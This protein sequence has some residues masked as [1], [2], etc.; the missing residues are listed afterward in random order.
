MNVL[1]AVGEPLWF[2]RYATS[3]VFPAFS[4]PTLRVS[5]RNEVIESGSLKS[6][7][8]WFE[9]TNPSLDITIL[10][11]HGGG[12]CTLSVDAYE[13]SIR[14]LARRL[15]C[16]IVSVDYRRAPEHPY[17]QIIGEALFVYAHLTEKLGIPASKI[18]V[19]GDSAGGNI[20]MSLCWKYERF[21]HYKFVKILLY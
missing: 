10:H 5:R 6:N 1:L 4:L 17:P 9:P 8:S 13:T 15:G 11:F 20:S 3:L 16:R 18:Y 19:M 21:L 14:R 7:L 2:L 12:F